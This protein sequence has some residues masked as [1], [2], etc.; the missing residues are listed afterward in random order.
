MTPVYSATKAGMHSFSQSL[1]ILL[2]G[3]SVKVFE[4]APPVIKT[5]LMD[6]LG[7]DHVKGS[8]PMS[9]EDLVRIII[10]NLKDDNFEANKLSQKKYNVWQG[11]QIDTL[12]EIS[13]NQPKVVLTRLL[14]KA[15]EI[16]NDTDERMAENIW[17][18]Q[19]SYRL[20]DEKYSLT[21]GL[22]KL[23]FEAGEQLKSNNCE[24]WENLS[25]FLDH[26]HIVVEHIIATLMLNLDIDYSDK[27]ID[28]LLN[29][30]Q[31]RLA[32]GIDSIEPEWILPSKLIEKFSKHC[33][34]SNF[35]ELENNI[36]EIG[37]SRPDRK[38][39]V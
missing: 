3:T 2:K 20:S 7:Y 10:K 12:E 30:N 26:T 31:T 35:E 36:I 29:N 14:P 18:N 1:R 22:K 6:N 25:P 8:N 5:P 15:I 13:L 16:I 17:F 38:S 34:D 39:V 28:W 27:V 37:V 23:I 21:E 4:V 32:C 9:T 24:L 33:S 11:S 19:F